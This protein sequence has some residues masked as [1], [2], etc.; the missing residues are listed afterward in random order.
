MDNRWCGHGDSGDIFL[1][2]G[3]FYFGGCDVRIRT[4]LGSCVAITMWH[5]QRRIGGLCHYPLAERRRREVGEGP[6]GRYAEKA[7][8]L[9]MHELEK[10]VSRPGDYVVKLFGGADQFP[11]R[12]KPNGGV[13]ERDIDAGRRLLR[14]CGFTINTE[15]LRGTGHRNVVFDL[16]SGGVWVKHSVSLL[17]AE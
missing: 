3:E 5:P 10:Y 4:L 14:H 6:D 12:P 13:P 11:C 15:H 2:P 8:L 16:A 1:R 7:L 9:I 17:E